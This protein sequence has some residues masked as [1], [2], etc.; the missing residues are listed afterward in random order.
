LLAINDCTGDV[1]DADLHNKRLRSSLD[2]MRYIK[3]R[4]MTTKA[5]KI[6]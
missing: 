1:D 6:K 3:E 2:Q 4:L 5:T